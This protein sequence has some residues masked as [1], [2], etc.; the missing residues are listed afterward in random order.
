M[1]RLSGSRNGVRVA[2]LGI[3]AAFCAHPAELKKQTLDAWNQYLVQ[4]N[5]RIGDHAAPGH[6]F[7]QVERDP[8]RM[9]AVRDG[10]IL[11]GT[12]GEN[13]PQRV[14]G[15]LVHHWM[16]DAFIPGVT[17]DDVLTVTRNYERYSD[18]YK[19][20]VAD[21][22]TITSGVSRDEFVLY[23][24]NM[25]V[26]SRNVL[27]GEY[28]SNFIRLDEKRLYVVS[29]T[30]QMEEIRDFGRPEE[31][32]LP[33]GKGTGYIWRLFSTARLEEDKDGVYLEMEAIA[34]SRDIPMALHWFADPIVR[35][36]SHDS[37]EKSMQDTARAAKFH[38][39]IAQASR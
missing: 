26:L 33:P 30:K 34:L 24:Q 1:P 19:P 37:L 31:T 11:V 10:A 18:M 22:K 36:I 16:G 23:L 14:T 5:A 6:C 21:A 3:L 38:S 12:V 13:S 39:L 17:L 8:R 4:E 9:Q 32:H 35:R 15:G 28:I 27:K 29:Q 20:G 2:V 25:S 7:L